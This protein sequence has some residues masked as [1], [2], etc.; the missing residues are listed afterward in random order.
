ME[1]ILSFDVDRTLVDRNETSH[2]IRDSIAKALH[3]AETSDLVGV[4]LNTGRDLAA[5]REFDASLGIELD[6]FFLSG[7]GERLQGQVK[8]HHTSVLSME[9]IATASK[10]SRVY[11]VPFLDIKTAQGVV[12]I[13]LREAEVSFG[14]QKPADWYQVTRP[15]VLDWNDNET[16]EIIEYLQPLRLEI[17]CKRSRLKTL[18]TMLA[19]SHSHSL[20]ILP[21]HQD[22]SDRGLVHWAFLQVLSPIQSHNKGTALKAYVEKIN[23]AATVV[24]F[25]DSDS[26]HNSDVL[27]AEAL[28]G[29]KYVHV[30]WE[31]GE[32]FKIEETIVGE[33]RRYL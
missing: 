11:G 26:Q 18:Q 28:P 22:F 29:A 12:Q 15:R 10:A 30:D 9:L 27:V 23:P 21:V 33:I 17:P 4:V 16:L 3:E 19:V 24:H 5:L 13:V 2:G 20:E 7:R 8:A 14:T 32:K 6:A 31:S 25:G 1:I